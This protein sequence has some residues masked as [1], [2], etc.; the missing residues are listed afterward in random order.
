MMHVDLGRKVLER[1]ATDIAVI[2]EI[3]SAPKLLGKL[4]VMLIVPK[5]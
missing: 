5:K 1:L 3:E 4:M 2:G